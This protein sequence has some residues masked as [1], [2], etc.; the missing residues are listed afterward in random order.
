MPVKMLTFFKGL[1][2]LPSIL[3]QAVFGL[4]NLGISCI[5]VSDNRLKLKLKQETLIK[6]QIHFSETMPKISSGTTSGPSP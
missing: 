2:T 1:C 5:P 3:N 6:D 4:N